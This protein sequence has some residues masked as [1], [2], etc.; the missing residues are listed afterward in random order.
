MAMEDQHLRCWR[1]RE[2]EAPGSGVN[3]PVAVVVATRNRAVLLQQRT[4]P[5]ILRQ[6][7]LPSAVVIVNDGAP[8]PEATR[9]VFADLAGRTHL[10]LLDN[11]R[12][13]G[14]AGAWNTGLQWLRD[15]GFDG[16]VA[17]LDDDDTWDPQHLAAN[18]R[19]ASAA[20][21]AFAVT[22]LRLLVDGRLEPRPLITSL[23]V[24]DFLVGNPGWQGSNNFVRLAALEAIGGFDERLPSMHDRD[25]AVRL[26]RHPGISWVLVP[27]WTSTWFLGT[28]GCLTARSSTKLVALRRFLEKHGG[29]MRAED[30]R[31]FFERAQQLFGYTQTEIE[32]RLD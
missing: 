19:A 8:H 4:V 11:A 31:A 28:P 27:E 5:S 6:T 17:I 16:F 30:R 10:Q 32:C 21:A 3:H 2:P 12:T 24:S 14:P 23:A 13:P 1:S 15:Q 18:L 20:D 22:G 26:L 29:L 7:A 25:L 9:D